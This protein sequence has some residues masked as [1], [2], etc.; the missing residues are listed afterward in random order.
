MVSPGVYSVFEADTTGTGTGIT[1][2]VYF[3]DVSLVQNPSLQYTVYEVVTFGV[4]VIV[5]VISP[6]LHIGVPWQ[7]VIVSVTSSPGQIVSVLQTTAGVG[8]GVTL[9]LIVFDLPLPH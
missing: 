2:I 6:V 4:T 1:V 7:L 5:L 8:V 9:I 3:C